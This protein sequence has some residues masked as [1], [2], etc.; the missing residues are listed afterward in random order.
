MAAAQTS[1]EYP[2]RLEIDYPES[3][4]RLTTF[5]RIIWL[6]PI[7]FVI[8]LVGGGFGA[9]GADNL[10]FV[11]AS[12]GG[13]LFGGPLVMILFRQKYPS[14]WF[15]WSLELT[16]FTTR[17]GV[18]A[19]LLTDKYPS[20]DETQSVHLDLDYPNVEEDLNRWLPLVKWF[21]LIPHYL[22]LAVL[23]IVA[24][25]AVVIAW[26]A[27]LFTGVYPRGIFDFIVGVTR[28]WLRV[29]AYGFLLITDRYPP[30]GLE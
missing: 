20:T 9:Y 27:I 29:Q 4:D 11:Y 7:W 18:Y 19:A 16:R 25:F 12:G 28:W 15:D 23:G 24:F 8:A 17:V 21:L 30:F 2:A 22:V 13:V 5:F 14:W 10:A 6:I 3:L 1:T 26:F